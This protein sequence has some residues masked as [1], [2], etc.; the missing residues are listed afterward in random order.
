MLL[1]LLLLLLL[2]MCKFAIQAAAICLPF[3]E[4]SL[5]GKS[6]KVYFCLKIALSTQN[7][8]VFSYDLTVIFSHN[9]QL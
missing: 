5:I 8:R 3:A 1:L 6:E 9:L 2:L 4:T 7:L